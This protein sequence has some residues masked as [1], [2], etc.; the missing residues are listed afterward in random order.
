VSYGQGQDRTYFDQLLEDRLKVLAGTV[1][2]R[3]D[4]FRALKLGLAMLCMMGLET[5]YAEL[6]LGLPQS[7]NRPLV[8]VDGVELLLPSSMVP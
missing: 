8:W 3:I 4:R 1:V 6:P 7:L 5:T 2:E